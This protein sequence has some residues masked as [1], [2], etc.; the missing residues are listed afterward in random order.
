[1]ADLQNME[2]REGGI[3]SPLADLSAPLLDDTQ[4]ADFWESMNNLA[5]LNNVLNAVIG[6]RNPDTGGE[7]VRLVRAN[8]RGFIDLPNAIGGDNNHRRAGLMSGLDKHNLDNAAPTNNP[9][10]T[11]NVTV[12]TKNS[13]I[14]AAASPSSAQNTAV[15]TEGQLAA[16]RNAIDNH[17]AATRNAIDNHIAATR[18]A[19]NRERAAA[20]HRHHVADINDGQFPLNRIPRGTAN[21][22]LRGMGTG[23]DPRYGQ[24]HLGTDVTGHLRSSNIS[25]RFGAVHR[26]GAVLANVTLP[27]MN[28]GDFQCLSITLEADSRRKD[29]MLPSGGQYAF[30][31]ILTRHQRAHTSYGVELGSASA[32]IS[33][34]SEGQDGNTSIISAVNTAIRGLLFVRRIR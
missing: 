1:M 14:A 12:P 17:I 2:K 32:A 23:S 15:A 33:V 24:I 4:L 29:I 8:D 16:T 11:G 25:S 18:D 5:D 27:G 31:G 3:G 20:S 21:T 28:V 6:V 34:G 30:C 13:A 7:N 26:I 19:I 9:R 10:F 22:V